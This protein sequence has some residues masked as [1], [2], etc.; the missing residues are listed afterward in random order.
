[1]KLRVGDT[2]EVISGKDRGKRGKIEYLIPKENL[3]VVEK[4]NRWKK[5]LKKTRQH[6]QG[7]IVEI[8]RPIRSANAMIVCPHCG[9]LT[10]VKTQ[11]SKD[12]KL[13][14]CKKCHKTLDAEKKR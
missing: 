11:L 5:H 13:R 12:A 2:V 3:V 9:K 4:I 10:R 6:P 1:M 7:G 8:S 14:L